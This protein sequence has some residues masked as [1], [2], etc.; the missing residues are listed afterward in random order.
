MIG[1]VTANES[2]CSSD[3]NH[4]TCLRVSP[5]DSPRPL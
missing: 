4:A 1:Q 3:D 5:S 2:G